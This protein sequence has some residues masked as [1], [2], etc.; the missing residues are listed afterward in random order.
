PNSIRPHL[1]GEAEIFVLNEKEGGRHKPFGAGYTP[2][3]YFGAADVPGVLSFDQELINPGERATVRF[4]LLRPV[5]IEPGMRFA[6]REGSR[7]VGAGVITEV[8]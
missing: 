4:S 6:M 1:E 3:F 5:A 7:T 2:Q 8:D